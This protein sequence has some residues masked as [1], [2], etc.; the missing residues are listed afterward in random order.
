MGYDTSNLHT[1]KIPSWDGA[2]IVYDR[3]WMILDHLRRNGFVPYVKTDFKIRTMINADMATLIAALEEG[4]ETPVRR[5]VD[6]NLR[7]LT[8]KQLAETSR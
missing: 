4:D 7:F 1:G 5:S 3:A 6:S 8:A 2:T